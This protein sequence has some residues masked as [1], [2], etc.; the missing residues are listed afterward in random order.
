VDNFCWPNIQ[1]HPIDNP[2]GKFKAAQLVRSC[3]A[4]KAMCEAF[5]IP[6]LSGKDSMYVDGHL[7]GRYG[8]THKVSALPTLQ[9]SAV[10]V[11]DDIEKCVTMDCKVPGDLVYVIGATHDEL[12][13]SEY[14]ERFGYVGLNV[15]QVRPERL[16]PLYRALEAAVSGGLAA[17]VHG[18]YRGGLGVHMAWVAMAGC[19]GMEIDLRNVPE[20]GVTRNDT[21]L[22]S[23]SAGR[24]IVTLDPGNRDAFEA[25][26]ADL[27][28]ACAG[29]VT[30]DPVLKIFGLDGRIRIEADIFHLKEAWKRPFGGL[31]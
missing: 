2:D 14:Y 21:I 25:L 3:R 28:C 6:L 11:I 16:I 31:I 18:I 20:E 24:F 4:L 27:P 5:G 7:P 1:Y 13:A 10:S 26:F 23:E 12:G 22:F 30:Q 29:S 17:S 15:P 9:F 8:E 19:L